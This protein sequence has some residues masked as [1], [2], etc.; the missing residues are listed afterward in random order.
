MTGN[1]G[2]SALASPTV[3]PA[4]AS[5]G[6]KHGEVL[7]EID[8]LIAALSRFDES[9]KKVGEDREV[10]LEDMRRFLRLKEALR[11]RLKYDYYGWPDDE[12][13]KAMLEILDC[14][15]VSDSQ[16]RRLKCIL[17]EAID[18]YFAE[19]MPFPASDPNGNQL[20]E[21][22]AREFQRFHGK[23]LLQHIGLWRPG[24]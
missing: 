11:S 7:G 19:V 2:S 13:C 20:R 15:S 16:W 12:S 6:G 3:S 5:R 10:P 21:P 24:K 14:E 4:T 1:F 22:P 18:I 8:G 17:T 23:G 9:R